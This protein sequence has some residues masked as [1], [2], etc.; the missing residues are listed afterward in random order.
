V[1]VTVVPSSVIDES[2]NPLPFHLGMLFV[3]NAP[4]PSIEM[5]S[6][7]TLIPVPAP[8]FK[9]NED[10]ISPP[11]VKPS[12]AEIVTAV[13]STFLSFEVSSPTVSAPIEIPVPAPTFK[14]T[15][16]PNETEPPLVKPL[17]ATTV[18]LV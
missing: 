6:A 16:P 5:S 15:E 14:V 11:P 12:P 17:P 8:T 18:T 2:A 7:A 13:W 10:A 4:A 3:V 9:L 1:I